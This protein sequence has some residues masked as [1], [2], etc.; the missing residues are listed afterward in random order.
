MKSK[1]QNAMR[2]R[3]DRELLTLD[4][5]IERQAIIIEKATEARTDLYAAREAMLQA[6]VAL[7][8]GGEQQ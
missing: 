5:K 2:S 7:R 4:Q 3:I 1:E 8:T 6:A